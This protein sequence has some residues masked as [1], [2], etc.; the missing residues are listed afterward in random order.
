MVNF[1][2]GKGKLAHRCNLEVDGVAEGKYDYRIIEN[3][4][5]KYGY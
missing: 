1:A 4:E 3:I 5:M 2:K